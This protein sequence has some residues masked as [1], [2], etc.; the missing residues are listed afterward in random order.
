MM[1]VRKW[2]LSALLLAPLAGCSSVSD[3]H[4]EQT[5][6]ARARAA[7]RSHGCA[8]NCY[9]KDYEAGWKDGFYDIATGGKGCPPLVAPCKYWAPEQLLEDHDR[10]RNA[11]Y[12][13]FQD[14]VAC[15]LRYPQTHYLKLWTSCECP[16]PQCANQCTT[17]NCGPCGG[18]QMLEGGSGLAVPGEYIIDDAIPM[19]IE[20]PIDAGLSTA[21][22]RIPT[23][24]IDNAN[25]PGKLKTS[26][27]AETKP[28]ITEAK[29]ADLPKQA[30][31]VPTPEKPAS[32]TSFA[33]AK[34]EQDKAAASAVKS[35]PSA[36]QSA[37]GSD[38]R[39]Q[40]R[41]KAAL[42]FSSR[43]PSI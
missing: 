14:G 40:N 34:I 29:P 20:G 35:R 38:R 26:K 3:F 9:A 4:Y 18:A 8:P 5:Q 19:P 37:V 6:H 43:S 21:T 10:A 7:W 11:Y 32:E 39:S 31:V 12:S 42:V 33:P 41:T 22:E 16:G 25:D 30:E 24:E 36:N 13:G 1:T 17:G 28:V 2:L 15:S 27:P 23:T